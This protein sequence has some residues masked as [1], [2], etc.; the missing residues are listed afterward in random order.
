[1]SRSPSATNL[2]RLLTFDFTTRNGL[3]HGLVWSNLA[4]AAV[5]TAIL[6]ASILFRVQGGAE[7]T[8][9]DLVQFL[10]FWGYVLLTPALGVSALLLRSGSR[11]YK[12]TSWVLLGIW[13]CLLIAGTFLHS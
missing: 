3:A 5:A 9:V 1:M 6:G 12:V 8:V 2:S 7:H 13:S 10:A 4:L 11:R